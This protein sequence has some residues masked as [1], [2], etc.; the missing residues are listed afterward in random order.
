MNRRLSIIGRC[1]LLMIFWLALIASVKAQDRLEYWFDRYS[2][3]KQIAISSG[4]INT[5]L[6]VSELSN[7]FHTLYMRVKSGNTYSPVTSSIFLKHSA[8]TG[9]IIEYWFDDNFEQRASTPVNTAAEVARVIELDMSDMT[10]F[11]LGLHRLNMRVVANGYSPVYSDLVMRLPNGEHSE[12][13][14]WLD[15]DYENRQ[16]IKGSSVDG[17]TIYVGSSLDFS[18][19]PSG[20]HRLKFRIT[21]NGFDD[22]PIYEE[23]VLVTRLY[24]NQTDVIIVKESHWL[25]NVLGTPSDIFNPQSI[26]TQEYTLDP[27]QYQTGQHVFYVQFRNSAGVWGETNATYFYKE[28]SG[29]LYAGRMPVEVTGIDNGD[30]SEQFGCNYHDGTLLIDCQSPKLASTGII[31]VCD[32]TGK[33][34][35]RQSVNCKNGIHAEV[36]VKGPANRLVIVRLLSG[37]VNISKKIII[38]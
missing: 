31:L 32:Q 1:T 38:R 28:E 29:K 25:D 27:N 34:I 37:D 24:N 36:N 22:G 2:G 11:P 9:T 12:L 19:A 6:D 4:T 5:A 3:A 20:M 26:V 14:Y 13:T 30:V 18:S 21:T 17:R 16:K 15:D 8:S 10:K 35:T 23:P 33:V 7:G